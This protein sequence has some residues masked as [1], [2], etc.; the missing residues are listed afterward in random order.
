MGMVQSGEGK[1]QRVVQG[2]FI[3]TGWQVTEITLESLSVETGN[4]CEPGRWQW[5]REGTPNDKKDKPVD[6]G[7]ITDIKP[8]EKRHVSGG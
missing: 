5:K 8:S 4:G 7:G 1:W 6:A 3:N 2:Q